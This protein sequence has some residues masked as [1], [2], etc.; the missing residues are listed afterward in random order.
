MEKFFDLYRWQKKFNF[1]TKSSG[2]FNT[3]LL[4]YI[5]FHVTVNC[6]SNLID[7]KSSVPRTLK[8]N[9]MF[10]FFFFLILFYF[11]IKIKIYFWL[12]SVFLS[13]SWSSFLLGKRFSIFMW[14]WSVSSPEDMF[15]STLQDL[16]W[17]FS[18]SLVNFLYFTTNTCVKSNITKFI[19]Y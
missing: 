10:R 6:K 14:F 5:W 13:W 11:W 17:V 1:I 3:Y 19:S 8:W 16:C 15:L 12:L 7:F 9:T 2:R 4:M 18:I